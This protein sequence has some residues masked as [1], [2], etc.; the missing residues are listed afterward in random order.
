MGVHPQHDWRAVAASAID[1]WR[2]A[3]VDT[4]VEDAPRDWFAPPAPVAAPA[5]T[6]PGATPTSSRTGTDAG[7]L[8]TTLDAFLAWRLG[9]DAPEHGWSGISIAASG[10]ADAA[11]M[12]LVDC[13][14]REDGPAATM[15]SGAPGRLF[16]RMLAAIGLSRDTVHLAAVCA[17]RPAAG[18]VDPLVEARLATIA[19][20]HIQLLGPK[21]V[22]LL[23]NAASR[24]ILGADAST[25]RGG[26]RPIN[27][28]GR[29]I[30]AVA[31]FHPRFLIERPAMKAE[32]WKDLQMLIEGIA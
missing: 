18:R 11:V 20:H 22:L 21:R 1:W 19:L 7:A 14:D 13:P 8:P 31:S 12:V 4:L 29:E 17:R 9:A 15:L 26:L 23:G 24:A 16:D 28:E 30:M 6:V 10:P 32:A 25:A 27:H 3:G 2:D 5:R